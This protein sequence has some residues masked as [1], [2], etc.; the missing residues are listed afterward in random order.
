[1]KKLEKLERNNTQRNSSWEGPR[2]NCSAVRNTTQFSKISKKISTT[3]RHQCITIPKIKQR[4]E[5]WPGRKKK[6]VLENGNSINCK[7]TVEY[8][9]QYSQRNHDQPRIVNPPELS[10]KTKGRVKIFSESPVHSWTRWKNH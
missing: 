10:L 2:D 3:W 6:I 4:Y 5:K 9:L 7:E 1:V 8:Y